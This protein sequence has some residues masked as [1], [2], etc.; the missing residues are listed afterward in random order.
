MTARQFAIAWRA[1]VLVG[2]CTLVAA[3]LAT[4][5]PWPRTWGT[6]AR[7]WLWAPVGWVVSGVALEGRLR[8]QADEEEEN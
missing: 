6:D 7:M 4:W 5:V 8:S 3:V 1:L 2:A